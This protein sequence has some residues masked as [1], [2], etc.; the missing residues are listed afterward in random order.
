[1][2]LDVGPTLRAA[3]RHKGAFA[4]VVMQLAVSFTILASLTEIGLGLRRLARTD[5]GYDVTDLIGVVVRVPRAP[6]G[7][8][9]PPAMP[10]HPG[11]AAVTR[12]WPPLRAEDEPPALYTAGAQRAHG[13]T[14]FA[15][16]SIVTVLGLRLVEGGLPPPGGPRAAGEPEPIIVTRALRAKLFPGGAPAVGAMMS[17]SDAAPGRVVAVVENIILREPFF[18]DPRQIVIRLAAPPAPGLGHYVVRARPG[19]GE[20]VLAALAGALGPSGPARAVILTPYGRVA[21]HFRAASDGLELMFVIIGITVSAIALI[22]ALAVSSFVVT[23]RRRDVGVRR[24]LGARRRD[25][26]RYF[27]VEASLMAVL[28]IA[29]GLALTFAILWSMRDLFE[30]LTIDGR[31]FVAVALLLLVDSVAAALLPAR[32]AALIPPSTASRGG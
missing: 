19:Q 22:G 31:Y 10:A 4:L 29:L 18:S 6:P 20:A 11:I 7:A 1:M 8:P 32:R 5:L 2:G 14:V 21:P 17:A 26:L 25:I 23:A 28:G 30:S 16:P 12:L 24:A 27:L 15:D 13:W 9:E 3:R